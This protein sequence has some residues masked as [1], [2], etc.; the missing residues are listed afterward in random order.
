MVRPRAHRLH[1]GLLAVPATLPLII[2]EL[3]GSGTPLVVLHGLLGSSRNWQSAGVALAERGHRVLAPDLRNHG[4]SPW[5]DD[6]SY[7]ALAQDVIAMLDGLSL[8][9]VHLVGHSMGGKAAMRLV[10]ERPDLV[11]R[12][13][14]VDIAPRVYSDRVRVEFAAMNAL[15]LAAVKSR[16]D[17]E[18]KLAAQVSEWGMRQFIL[19]NLGQDAEGRWRWTVNREALTRALP[20]ILGNPL[21]SGETWDGPTRFLR[22]GKSN[23]VRDE[24]VATI[25]AHFPRADIVT[26]PDSG[27][28]PHFEARAGFVEATLG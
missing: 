24:D 5:G 6:C 26:L 9:P 21:T 17:A 16:K 27:H 23:Y 10:M 18:E 3:G 2:R 8:G 19:T 15:D 12:L 20:E 22:G 14:V 11:A 25:R 13:T 28:N 1:R 4:S 7:A